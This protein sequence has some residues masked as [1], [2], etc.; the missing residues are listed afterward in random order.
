[1][2]GFLRR[3]APGSPEDRFWQWFQKHEAELIDYDPNTDGHGMVHRVGK[4]L[5]RVHSGLNFEFGGPEGGRKEFVVSA[6]G[7]KDVFPAVRRLVEAAPDLPRWKITAF[8]PRRSDLTDM[9]LKIGE[10]DLGPEDITF[11]AEPEGKKLDLVLYLPDYESTPDHVYEQAAFLFLDLALGEYDV[12]TRIGAIDFRPADA[13]PRD[14][15]H[16]LTELPAL[17][18]RIHN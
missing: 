1:M 5:A 18:D 15:A 8:R 7:I 13:R 6:G 16:A 14:G 9:R 3:K 17:V 12:A 10:L 4:E 11:L 2:F